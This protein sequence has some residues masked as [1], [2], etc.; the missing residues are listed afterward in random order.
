MFS[1]LFFADSSFTIWSYDWYIKAYGLFDIYL[2]IYIYIYI[3]TSNICSWSKYL[4]LK[5]NFVLNKRES[6]CEQCML[7]TT[8]P[9]SL[10][11]HF[12]YFIIF[13]GHVVT[14]LQNRLHKAAFLPLFVCMCVSE[15]NSRNPCVLL[16][17][18]TMT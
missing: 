8:C 18:H 7:I 2:N 12:P 9:R 1:R 3:Y 10:T 6:G 17:L 16:A 13:M 15:W 11:N 14:D 5:S 4:I